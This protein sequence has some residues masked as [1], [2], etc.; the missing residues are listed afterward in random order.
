[1]WKCTKKQRIFVQNSKMIKKLFIFVKKY[2]IIA[3]YMCNLHILHVFLLLFFDVQKVSIMD[4]NKKRKFLIAGLIILLVLLIGGI[5]TVSLLLKGRVGVGDTDKLVPD[6]PPQETDPNQTP[7]ESDPGGEIET[8]EGQAAINLTYLAKATADLSE[9]TVELYYAN[10]SRSKKDVVISLVVDGTVICRSQRITPGHQ[11]KH[12]MILDDA[13][14][15]LAVG[16][17]DAKFVVGCYDSET[18][19]KELVELEGSG[20]RLE[21]VE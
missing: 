20:V 19:K 7:M 18:N 12:L 15:K 16:G 13:K 9:G 6:Y 14:G 5:I 1:M 2:A 3:L 8:G 21:V 11:I 4:N 10:P 17:Y